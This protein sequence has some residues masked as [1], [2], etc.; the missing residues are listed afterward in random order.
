MNKIAKNYLNSWCSCTISFSTFPFSR[1]PPPP[2][3]DF[4]L[5]LLLQN[6]DE[7]EHIVLYPFIPY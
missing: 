2:P 4:S 7:I 5:P 6:W 3:S 1:P